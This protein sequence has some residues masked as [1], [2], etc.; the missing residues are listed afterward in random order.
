M[1][2]DSAEIRLRDGTLAKFRNL[3]PEDA[4]QTIAAMKKLYGETD[5]LARC[6]DE[7]D[8]SIQQEE[9]W[10]EGRVS[11][12]RS[13]MLGAF[14]GSEEAGFADLYP[15]GSSR[16][17]RHRGEISIAILRRW[18]SRG[19]GRAMLETLISLAPDLGY[20]QLELQVSEQNSI[21]LGLY[22][23]LGFTETGRFPRAFRLNDGSFADLIQMVRFLD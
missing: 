14:I 16:K 5:F 20:T 23:N 11:D 13:L 1:K 6:P 17:T 8:L 21:A 4:A 12:Q 9:A 18:Q 2:Y 7:F 3:R 15:L 22:S 10:I 19:L